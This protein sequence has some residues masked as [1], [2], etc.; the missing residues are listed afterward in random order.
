MHLPSRWS[1]GLQALRILLIGSRSGRLCCS[2][3]AGD[4][5]SFGRLRSTSAMRS[6]A[7]PPRD[8]QDG[9]GSSSTAPPG[10]RGT[11][12]LGNMTTPRQE[13]GGT[14]AKATRHD[15]RFKKL[16]ATLAHAT[17]RVAPWFRRAARRY[18]TIV[19]KQRLAWRPEARGT[20]RFWVTRTQPEGTQRNA[21]DARQTQRVLNAIAAYRQAL[22]RKGDARSLLLLASQR[23]LNTAVRSVFPRQ[24]RINTLR[25]SE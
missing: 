12:L 8:C 6:D 17:S 19:S 20:A 16:S 2:S 11:E 15:T 18:A 10:R 22:Q 3:L 25:V 21:T 5:T 9:K 4:T 23:V 13:R 1:A 7:S 14:V 24:G